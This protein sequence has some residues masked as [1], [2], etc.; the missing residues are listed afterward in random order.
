MPLLCAGYHAR[1]TRWRHNWGGWEGLQRRGARR[2]GLGMVGVHEIRGARGWPGHCR[3][4][5]D[6]AL[7]D[8]ELHIR[9]HRHNRRI[10]QQAH[11]RVRRRVHALQ[12]RRSRPLRQREWRGLV[13]E[14]GGR[15]RSNVEHRLR[16]A[17]QN[18]KLKRG[19][20]DWRAR[21]R[22]RACGVQ[23]ADRQR[24]RVGQRKGVGRGL[25]SPRGGAR[26]LANV[27]RGPSHG[28]SRLPIARDAPRGAAG[29]ART[30]RAQAT[31]AQ[32]PRILNRGR[33]VRVP[34]QDTQ[35]ATASARRRERAHGSVNILLAPLTCVTP[36]A[37][38]P[39]AGA[40]RG[41]AG[42]AF[43]D[44]LEF[45][46]PPLWRLAGRAASENATPRA[47]SSDVARYFA[48][49]RSPAAKQIH[50]AA[51]FK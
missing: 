51:T 44:F 24:P 32:R 2:R 4:D 45:M 41:A 48:R 9:A 16:G 35:C 31:R 6:L 34:T 23:R 33:D 11:L 22:R 13:C 43:S 50:D 46:V 38:A 42:P 37:S 36:P 27:W 5:M 21:A 20:H 26:E 40:P 8:G 1:Q 12:R 10:G 15:W 30:V 28:E 19:H 29:R 39:R 3:P 25:R 14:L 49:R 47:S 7:A 17:R 18:A